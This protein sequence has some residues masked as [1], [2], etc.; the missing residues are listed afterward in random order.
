MRI[1][2]AAIEV[3]VGLL[4]IVFLLLGIRKYLAERNRNEK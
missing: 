4:T 1:V 2:M 3:T